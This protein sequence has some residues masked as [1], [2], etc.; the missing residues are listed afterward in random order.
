MGEGVD[1]MLLLPWSRTWSSWRRGNPCAEQ[2]RACT[3]CPCRLTLHGL[4]DTQCCG[5]MASDTRQEIEDTGLDHSP[6]GTILLRGD[7]AM[8]G[9][10]SGCCNSQAGTAGT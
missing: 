1:T 5:L 7:V 3:G 4:G 9:D 10:I 2:E 8:S 6:A